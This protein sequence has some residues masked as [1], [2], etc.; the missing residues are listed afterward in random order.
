MNKLVLRKLLSFQ[1]EWSN[2]GEYQKYILNFF[3]QEMSILTEITANSA[4]F[5]WTD[6]ANL[7]TSLIWKIQ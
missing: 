6:K 2:N 1:N 7:M 3:W 5:Q 4:V